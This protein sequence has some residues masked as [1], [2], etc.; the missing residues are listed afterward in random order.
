MRNEPAQVAVA[1][2]VRLSEL[3]RRYIGEK[4]SLRL[5]PGNRVTLLRDGVDAFP[6]MLAAIRGA[7]KRVRLETYIFM[8]D[9]LG[10]LF[11]RALVEAA[12]RGVRVTVLYD[13]FGSWKAKGSFFRA[14]RKRG[15]DVHA[16]R[17]LS[18]SQGWRRLVQ[19]D[20]RKLLV[21][22]GE[23]AFV[24]GINIAAEWAPRHHPG[25]DGWRDDALRV[26][27]PAAAQ[28]ERR[29]CASWRVAVQERLRAWRNRAIVSPATVRGDLSV[30][31][32][33]SRRSIH[34]AY[35][36]AIMAATRTVMI[37][38]G[39]FIP[40][41]K[42]MH[43]LQSAAKRGVNVGLILAGKSDHPFVTWATRG[44]YGRLLESGVKIYEWC[45]AVLHAKTAVVDG[46]WA[47]IGS[48]N[49]DR[50]SFFYN[51]EVNVVF[52]D[53]RYAKPLEDSFLND[54]HVCCEIT[55][56]QWKKR[57]WWKRALE[58]LAY[59]FRKIL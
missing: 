57:P 13:A 27:G 26:E 21:V 6:E 59:S 29:F 41:R 34:R 32:L 36:H 45:D 55:L 38:A 25:G 51:H 1:D 31:I 11:A 53:P 5:L 18:I 44:F 9:A 40:D 42:L 35:L 8:D 3:A 58:R 19:R 12:E 2:P 15:V 47:T 24:G 56:A 54:S 10:Q 7:R 37:A 20:H 16:F 33:T 43:A 22:D 14:M 52:A 4:D 17:P 30:G 46:T 50:M 48:F 49:L 23:I 39:Y 28:L